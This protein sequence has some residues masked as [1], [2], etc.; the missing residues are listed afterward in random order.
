MEAAVLDSPHRTA[1]T[2]ASCCPFQQLIHTLIAMQQGKYA[3][4]FENHRSH[5]CYIQG[6]DFAQ[7]GNEVTSCNTVLREGLEPAPGT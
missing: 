1:S 7:L 6:I 3:G 4:G 5:R 2:L